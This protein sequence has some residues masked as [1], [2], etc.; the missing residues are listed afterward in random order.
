MCYK[1]GKDGD[2]WFLLNGYYVHE[3]NIDWLGE[4]YDYYA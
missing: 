2:Y 1:I 3:S 4:Y